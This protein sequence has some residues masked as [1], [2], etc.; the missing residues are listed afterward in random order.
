MLEV[1]DKGSSS[2]SRPVPLLFV[3]GAW[4]AAWCW[5]QHF[6]DFFAA[7][8]YRALAVSLRGHGNSSSAKPLRTC[9]IADYVEDVTAVADSL[10]TKPVVIG[11]SMGGF[12][13]QK[14]LES[15]RAPAAVL[16]ASVPPQGIRAAMLRFARRHPWLAAKSVLTGDTMALV[17]TSEHIREYMFSHRTPEPFVSDCAGRFQQESKRAIYLD[18]MFLN[19]PTPEFVT[20]PVLVLSGQ[21]DGIFGDKEARAT[22]RAYSAHPEVF[23]DMGHEMMIEPGWAAVAQ[24][25]H[26]WLESR[27][28]TL[29]PAQPDQQKNLG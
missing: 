22:A 14:Y 29:T 25:I 7:K 8:G 6:L 15:R 9:S 26:I 1:I 13:V 27:E 17:S 3:H 19:L 21:C 5:D 18:M 4:Q 12:I 16:L 20:T 10:P 28:L 24:R 11:H 2:K 23:P